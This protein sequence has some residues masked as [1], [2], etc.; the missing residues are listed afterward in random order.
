MGA[1]AESGRRGISRRPWRSLHHS[2]RRGRLHGRASAANRRAG[3]ESWFSGDGFVT[4]WERP[5]SVSGDQALAIAN[6]DARQAYG[7]LNHFR[8]ELVLEDDGWHVD[9]RLR[10]PRMKGGGPHYVIHADT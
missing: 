3:R 10:D 4:T 6:A 7:E 8:V 9:F 5:I 1:W 2:F